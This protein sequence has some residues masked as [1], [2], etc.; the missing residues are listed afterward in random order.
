[1][2]TIYAWIKQSNKDTHFKFEKG[3]VERAA[4]TQTPVV[5]I[6]GRMLDA[7]IGKYQISIKLSRDLT[8]TNISLE[9]HCGCEDYHGR[10]AGNSFVQPCK[11][12][13][14]VMQAVN[15]EEI[16]AAF[17]ALSPVAAIPNGSPS[18]P[19]W[20]ESDEKPATFNERVSSAIGRAVNILA[21]EV[22][23]V[24]AAGRVPFLVGPTGCGK[25]SAVSQ[26]AL[27]MNTRFVETAGA[28]S[29]TDSDLVGVMMP[30][31][32]PMPGPIGKAMLH[33]QLIGE[34]V[35]I[36]LDEFLRFSPRAQ[37]SMMRVLLPKNAEIAQIMGIDH[38]GPVRVTSAPFWGE[39][40]APAELCHIVLAANPWGN[41]PDSALLRRVEPIQVRFSDQVLNLFTG[42]AHQAILTS[43]KGAADGSLP[44]PIEY[45]E[46]ARAT[47][48]SDD[49]FLSRYL[50]RVQVID[51]AAAT[52]FTALLNNTR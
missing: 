44:L 20:N 52:A 41:V 45:G 25:T 51:P 49:S 5:S 8:S 22:I 47:S 36:F 16:D 37:E 26:A 23:G 32:T 11:H 31:G 42:R 39:T 10:Y 15:L 28:D 48:D 38:N 30:N 2:A 24:L 29:W 18:A 1:M 9:A 14:R 7:S 4:L 40:W 3:R 21:E 27:M 46:I 13:I 6:H 19:V 50:A 33:A 34:P 17:A 43:W 35:L 12:I